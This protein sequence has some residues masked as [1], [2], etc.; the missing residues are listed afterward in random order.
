MS[1]AVP[2][3]MEEYLTARH[4]A[5]RAELGIRLA[6]AGAAVILIVL[7]G[8]L[9]EPINETRRESQIA[10]DE[11]SLK[12]L[13]PGIALL[14][15]T[16]TLR[17]L[18]IDM[19]FIRLENLKQENRFYELMQLSDWLCK[20]APR[21][22]SVWSYAAWN[23]AY[24]ISVCQYTP[25][26]RWMWVSNGI[27]ALRSR[28][29]V[30]NPKSIKLYK[31]LAWI[32]YHKIGDKL[33]DHHWF[34]KREL[35]VQME[36]I[37]GE[38]PLALTQEETVGAIREIR[39]APPDLEQWMARTPAVAALIAQL[40]E[41]GLQPDESL[42]HFVARRMRSHSNVSGFVRES[43]PPEELDLVARRKA[44][45]LAPENGETARVLLAAV[46]ARVIR[47][48]LHMDPKWMVQLMEDYGPIDWRSPFAHT[49]YW[50]TYGDMATEGALN[51]NPADS[52]NTVRFI[53]FALKT[54]ADG[55]K[56]VLEPNFDRPNHSFL[57][58]LPDIRFIRPM[59]EAY[60]H[61]GEKQFGDDPR[62]K[63]GTSGPNYFGGHRNFLLKSI[64]QLYLEGAEQN[65][66]EAKE[67]YFYLR[68]FD[69]Q[70]DGSVK[71]QYQVTFER[72]V[73]K[74]M[75]EALDTQ[76][77]AT[78]FISQL[79]LRS[80]KDLSDGNVSASVAHFKEARKWWDYYHRD[81]M[82]DR[83]ARRK[84]EPIGI[85]RRDVAMQF[86]TAPAEWYSLLQKARLWQAL[87][88]PTRQAV[89]DRVLAM[90]EK[91]CA[92]HDPPLDADKVMPLPPDMKQYRAN[93]DRVLQALERL[94]ESV[95]HGEKIKPE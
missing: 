84:L 14:T 16:G 36:L 63:P 87:D 77:G 38:P 47:E 45:L 80:L 62:F 81:M 68:K 40:G 6:A 78:T 93:P 66:E 8:M 79:L 17:A 95:S 88:R 50:A 52:M 4:G 1:R 39:D 76:A 72:F 92:A 2:T 23:M 46:R 5:Q 26:A 61:F 43:A 22:A 51:I 69:T 30:Y 56:I 37:L 32:F 53:F 41:V 10:L 24:N 12:G 19:A 28:G 49:L 65:L 59:H 94:D 35:A 25:E 55:G 71:P 31:E 27:E 60:L 29:L 13:P 44:V 15:K 3:K 90:V 82:Y 83:N 75:Y 18:A 21:Y 7:A 57:Q 89:Y 64:R 58:V 91:Q 70:Q 42:L 86:M 20:L 74:T 34:Y 85:M 73:F 54:M 48:K 11:E 33:D 9:V 67:Y